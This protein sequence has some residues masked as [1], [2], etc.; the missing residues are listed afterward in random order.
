MRLVVEVTGS[1][2]AVLQRILGAGLVIMYV[3]APALALSGV[4][5]VAGSYPDKLSMGGMMMIAVH[6][7]GRP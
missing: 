7:P 5:S 2:L 3:L 6:T 4:C 1:G